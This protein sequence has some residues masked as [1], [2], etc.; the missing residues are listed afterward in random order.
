M[1]THFDACLDAT[2]CRDC[3]QPICPTHP[4]HGDSVE[5]ADSGQLHCL[6][7]A[8]DCGPCL[9]EAARERQQEDSADMRRFG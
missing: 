5:C 4:E 6:D 2:T 3:D 1:T 7:C 8:R 9:S